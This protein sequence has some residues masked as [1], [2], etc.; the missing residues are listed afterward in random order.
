VNDPEGSNLVRVILQGSSNE[1]R[2]PGQTMPAFH[3]IYSD[4]EV[5]AL[6][7]YVIGRLSGKSGNVTAKDVAAARE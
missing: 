3:A 4:E 5:A 2:L 7:N 1:A 6:A